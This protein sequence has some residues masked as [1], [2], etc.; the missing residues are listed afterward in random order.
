MLELYS[1][2][3]ALGVTETVSLTE[4]RIN[5]RFFTL[6]GLTEFYGTIGAGSETGSTADTLLLI[7]LADGAG[8][9]DRI[10]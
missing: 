6:S 9:N 4:N 8:G 5:H 7:H 10:M 3:G 1:S 2:G